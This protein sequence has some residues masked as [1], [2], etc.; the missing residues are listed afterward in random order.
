MEATMLFVQMLKNM[1]HTHRAKG[2]QRKLH[3]CLDFVEKL[4]PWFSEEG[5]VNLVTLKKVGERL[6]NY[7]HVHGPG[8]ILSKLLVFG[9]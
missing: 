9:S 6:Q 4:C 3:N 1:L 8:K 2:G 7:N 5:T